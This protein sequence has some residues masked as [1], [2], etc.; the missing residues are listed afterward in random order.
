MRARSSLLIPLDAPGEERAI[1]ETLL[2][3]P[4]GLLYVPIYHPSRLVPG[5][6]EIRRYLYFPRKNGHVILGFFG[7][8]SK[9]SG[10]SV[11]RTPWD[12][13]LW[14]C[15]GGNRPL[16]RWLPVGGRTRRL[17]GCIGAR[18]ASPQSSIL[19]C[20]IDSLG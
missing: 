15:T 7:V 18:G 4:S 20:S 1:A 16:G 19:R 14:T 11:P 6:G 8:L 10:D 2:F 13:S 5:A 12:F 9:E 17:Q 3:G